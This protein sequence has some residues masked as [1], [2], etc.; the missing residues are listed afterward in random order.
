MTDRPEWNEESIDERVRALAA[1]EYHRPEGTVPRDAMWA[2]IV[3]AWRV[4]QVSPPDIAPRRTVRVKSW[5]WAAALAAGLLIGV[6][7]DRGVE[8]YRASTRVK[9]DSQSAA[10]VASSTKPAAVAPAVVTPSTDST[11]AAAMPSEAAP[12]RVATKPREAAIAEAQD[13]PARTPSGVRSPDPA[14][15]L[16]HA[17]AVQTL[18]QAEAL[19]TTYRRADDASR[20]TAS[21]RQ[22]ARWARDV[23]SSTRLLLDSPAAKDVQL[24]SLL[25]DLE[26]VLAQIVQLSG[27]P[28]QAGERELIERAM[29]DRDLLLRLR[30]AVPA[31]AATS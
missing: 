21:I 6:V 1:A 29:R 15:T 28:L 20:D 22:A 11:A 13:S 17:A 23:L 9:A 30:A 4:A 18:V 12:T 25:T 5:R 27:A 2:A 14:Q 31:G 10:R 24:R 16:Y 19:L 3:P 26:L 8:S 7:L